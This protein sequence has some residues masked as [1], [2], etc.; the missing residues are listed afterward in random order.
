LL[1]DRRGQ[2]RV[3]LRVAPSD[4]ASLV[5]EG[6]DGEVFRAPVQ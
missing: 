6:R 3:A 2:A 5:L 4:E 1:V